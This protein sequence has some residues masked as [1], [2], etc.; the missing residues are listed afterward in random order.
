VAKRRQSLQT[1]L[2]D[3]QAAGLLVLVL[4][5]LDTLEDIICCSTVSKGWN[6]T[7]QDV[8]PVSLTIPGHNPRL[9]PDGMLSTLRWMQQKQQRGHLQ[10]TW[11]AMMK[12]EVPSVAEPAC[13]TGLCVS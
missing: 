3:V 5:H 13:G 11:Q 2:T 4:N 8:R 6:T 7:C 9:D 10:V 12:A 1:T